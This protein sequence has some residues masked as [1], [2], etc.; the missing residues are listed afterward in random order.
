[1]TLPTRINHSII[2]LC[3]GVGLVLAASTGS[4]SSA[5]LVTITKCAEARSPG[6]AITTSAKWI[7]VPQSPPLVEIGD[8]LPEEY[9]VL[10][11]AGY[12]GLPPVGE[13]W[14]YYRVKRDVYRVENASRR[15]LEQVTD[16]TNGAFR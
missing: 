6:L 9:L 16:Q 10:M 1:M 4:G 8:V 7:S 5:C 15:V 12:Y 2:H 11:N 14:R 3:V 13:G